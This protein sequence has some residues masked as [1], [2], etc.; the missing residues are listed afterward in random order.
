[1]FSKRPA[2]IEVNLDF[3][4][5][6]LLKEIH[7]IYFQLPNNELPIEMKDMFKKLREKNKIQ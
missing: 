3:E 6:K 5:E 2:I 4:L 1:M 7:Y